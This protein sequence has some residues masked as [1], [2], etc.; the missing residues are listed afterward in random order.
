MKKLQQLAQTA[1]EA[2][3]RKKLDSLKTFTKTAMFS[4]WFSS[5]AVLKWAHAHAN[6]KWWVC[7]W[8]CNQIVFCSSH[9]SIGMIVIMIRL[10]NANLH[11]Q[12]PVWI[13]GKC[14]FELANAS[15]HPGSA[16]WISQKPANQKILLCNWQWKD[17]LCACGVRVSQV[18][19]TV[20]H[21]SHIS[22]KSKCE[23]MTHKD[24]WDKLLVGTYPYQDEKTRNLT[25]DL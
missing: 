1:M 5:P 13:G 8:D 20:A 23:Q 18:I 11:W 14:Q 19:S 9:F 4:E 7:C 25:R 17:S 22:K 6:E 2:S 15:P 21:L 3:K 12:T 16:A 24:E 10:T